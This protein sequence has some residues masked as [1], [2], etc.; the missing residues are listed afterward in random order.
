MT[1]LIYNC[2]L[3]FEY[4]L[5]SIKL[6]ITKIKVEILLKINLTYPDA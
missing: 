2:Y 5:I 3:T 1:T 6:L 4:L